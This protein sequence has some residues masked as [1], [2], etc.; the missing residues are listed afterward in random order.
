MFRSI[1]HTPGAARHAAS[2]AGAIAEACVS[3]RVHGRRDVLAAAAA[4]APRR[5]KNLSGKLTDARHDALPAMRDMIRKADTP[6][7]Q[8]ALLFLA[9]FEAFRSEAVESIDRA[10][11]MKRWS[12]LVGQAHL[13]AVPEILLAVRRLHQ[14]IHLA[15][16]SDAVPSLGIAAQRLLPR[17]I[18]ALNLEPS[19]RAANLAIAAVSSDPLARLLT[20][21]A[22]MRQ[23]D[24]SAL[25]GVALFCFDS[26][27][28]IARIALGHL[29]DRR[30]GQLGSWLMRLIDS[31]HAEIRQT[32]ERQLAGIGFEQLWAH[33]DS[34]SPAS[35][36]KAGVALMKIDRHF[37]RQLAEKMQ[38]SGAAERFRAVAIARAM[39]QESYFQPQLVGMVRD[40]DERVASSAAAALGRTEDSAPVVQ[41]LREALDHPDDRVRSNS[42]ESL[43]AL[44]R[45]ADAADLLRR[46]AAGRGARSRAAAIRAMM[47]LPMTQAL[48]ALGTMLADADAQH[49]VS[50]L[51]VVEHM[52]ITEAARRVA[53]MATHDDD[54]A[55][56]RRAVRIVRRMADSM[57]QAG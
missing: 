56:R 16:S 24:P 20:L 34:M 8:Q 41:A 52:G 1:E 46:I 10:G 33:W 32:A 14:P 35:R 13:T 49:R 44:N 42:V 2:L 54:P 17:W 7:I 39:K 3:Y 51:W 25:Q 31:P 27:L 40:S 38:S 26:Q 43:D 57:R 50:A 22:L 4:L 21:R 37:L 53:V 45:T 29:I 9:G 19:Q 5:F 48:A 15:P 47:K 11:G 6:E 30:W 36:E 12:D 18:E 28:P 23:S 55:V